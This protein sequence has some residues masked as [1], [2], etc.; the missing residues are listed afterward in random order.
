MLSITPPLQFGQRAGAWEVLG[1][2]LKLTEGGAVG[3]PDFRSR[4]ARPPFG[5]VACQP[6]SPINGSTRASTSL[7]TAAGVS[8]ANSASRT[9]QSKLLI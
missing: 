1:S 7:L 9:F 3:S 5:G 2:T 4:V 6:S 8:A